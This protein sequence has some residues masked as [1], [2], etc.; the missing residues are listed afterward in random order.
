MAGAV[1]IQGGGP[2]AKDFTGGDLGKC[3]CRSAS[4]VLMILDD[5]GI[6]K[7]WVKGCVQRQESW[8]ITCKVIDILQ[9]SEKLRAGN[10]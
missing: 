7:I 3:P 9:R 4:A 10:K 5:S 2:V 8:L 6:W 1:Q